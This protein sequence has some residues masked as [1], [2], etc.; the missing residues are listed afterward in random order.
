MYFL[1]AVESIGQAGQS[2]TQMPFGDR[3]LELEAV[4]DTTCSVLVHYTD[5]DLSPDLVSLYFDNPRKS[6]CGDGEVVD[7]DMHPQ[8]LLA[9]VRFSSPEGECGLPLLR[10]V[11]EEEMKVHYMLLLGHFVS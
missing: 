5:P 1:L 2:V 11:P 8:V 4:V 3:M 7:C 10:R 6:G 9:V